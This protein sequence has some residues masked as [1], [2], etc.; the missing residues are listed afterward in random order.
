MGRIPSKISRIEP[1]NLNLC[2]SLIIN[3][4]I[5]RFM[6]DLVIQPMVVPQSGKLP[7]VNFP[8]IFLYPVGIVAH[9]LINLA[10]QTP[11]VFPLWMAE[12]PSHLPVRRNNS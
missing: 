9:A 10:H 6:E 7:W 8:Q 3:D 2:K 12:C 5:L 4:G 11:A 1:L